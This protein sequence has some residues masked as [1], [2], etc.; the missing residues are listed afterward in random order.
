[1]TQSSTTCRKCG[2]PL[3]ASEAR[4]LCPVCLLDT[5]LGSDDNDAHDV[6]MLD[7]AWLE[8]QGVIPPPMAN[9]GARHFGDYEL[10]EEIGRGGMGIIYRANQISLQ[11]T[12]AVKTILTGPLAGPDFFPRFQTEAHAAAL[13]DHPNIVPIYEVGNHHGQ[14]YYSMPLIS[15]RNLAQVLKQDGPLPPRQAATMMAAI[16]R[17]IH[18]AHQRGVLHRDLK[19]ANILLDTGGQPHVTDFGLAKLLEQDDGLTLTQA[20]LGT[21]NYMAPEQ[22]AGNNS[23]LTTAADTYSLGAILFETLTGQRLFAAAT[24]LATI[25]RALDQE[26][27]RPSAILRSIP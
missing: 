17:A 10:F 3:R 9:P 13:L 15:G 2:V 20:A 16:A 1:M 19:P 5:S 12:V 14:P 11:R 6:G 7:T 8:Q 22:A 21:P 25:S 24:P 23:D 4:G 18:Y 27:P 26:P